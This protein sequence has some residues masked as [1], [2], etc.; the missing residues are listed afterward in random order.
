[1]DLAAKWT[2][3]AVACLSAWIP[4]AAESPK[5]RPGL[6]DALLDCRSIAEDSGRL[7]CYDAQADRLSSARKRGDIA[8]VTKQDLRES[9]RTL[10]GFPLPRFNLRGLKDDEP[11]ADR[12]ETTVAVAR[13]RGYYWSILLDGEAGTWETTEAMS[14]E[15]K[16]GDKIVIRKGVMGGYMAKLGSGGL[17]RIRRVS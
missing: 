13:P 8:V 9:R 14:R 7:A 4:A 10:F 6:F 11:D 12:I 1:M 15:P 3:L 16:H 17:V 5:D 2:L